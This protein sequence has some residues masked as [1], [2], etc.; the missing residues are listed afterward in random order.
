MTP[1]ALVDLTG[2]ILDYNP[3]QADGS[4]TPAIMLA[5]VNR[6]Y[7]REF[8]KFRQAASRAAAVTSSTTTWPAG[9]QTLDLTTV[10]NGAKLHSV[11]DVTWAQGAQG[12]KLVLWYDSPL[13]ARWPSQGG[14]S[15][16][17]Q[18]RLFSFAVPEVLTLGG[19]APTLIPAEHHEVIAWSAACE[20]KRIAD[21]DI[22]MPQTWERTLEDF[23][24]DFFKECSQPATGDRARI[25]PDDAEDLFYVGGI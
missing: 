8:R 11:Y 22:P 1:D 17:L 14:P 24:Y 12:T 19:A 21:P 13:V 18:L 2:L 3:D 20:L 15:Q 25:L 4:F 9:Q 23:Q 7:G 6:A 10:L 5:A 16:T